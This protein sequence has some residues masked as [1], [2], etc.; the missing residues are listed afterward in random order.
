MIFLSEY[1]QKN[2]LEEKVNNKKQGVFN[3]SNPDYLKN[4]IIDWEGSASSISNTKWI[5]FMAEDV[6][7][8]SIRVR[9]FSN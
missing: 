5:K 7:K 3:R 8:K 2:E 6:I 4:S 9:T 1:I